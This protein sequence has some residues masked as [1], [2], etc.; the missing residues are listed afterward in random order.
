MEKGPFAKEP[1]GVSFTVKSE[2]EETNKV[3]L[4]LHPR[5]GDKLYYEIGAAATTSSLRVE[6]PNNFETAQLKVSFLCVDSTSQHPTGNAV[7]WR[8]DISVKHKI[9]EKADGK[10]MTL[11]SQAGVNI[12][13]TTDGSDPKDSGG[14]YDGEFKIPAKAA[15]VQIVAEHGGEFYDNQSIKIEK[16][17][18][19]ITI[20][21]AKPLVLARLLRAVDTG[22]VYDLLALLKQYA[23]GVKDVRIVLHRKDDQG[24]DAGWIELTLSDKIM[25]HTEQ[26]ENTIANLKDSFIAGGRV[27]VELEC[28]T[29]MFKNGQAFLDFANEQKLSLS[30]LKQGEINQK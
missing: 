1:T 18:A 6:D 27:N 30:E 2:N 7:E 12:K 22:Q 23:T 15:F 13:Y 4:R 14:I 24:R 20:D 16:G 9:M 26:L 8:R 3:S 5:F 28:R 19:G 11:K 10:Y 29:A 17:A 25:T 21:K